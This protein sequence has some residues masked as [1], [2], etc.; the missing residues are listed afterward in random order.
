MRFKVG[1][2]G[3]SGGRG[4]TSSNRHCQ[5]Q[6]SMLGHVTRT[7]RS[8]HMHL[9]NSRHRSKETLWGSLGLLGGRRQMPSSPLVPPEA[10]RL[11]MAAAVA[12]WL[13][14]HPQCQA[15]QDW[16]APKNYQAELSDNFVQ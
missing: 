11:L 3:G 4:K 8:S 13:P 6:T 1:Q 14:W 15:A 16:A 9:L 2:E 12:I 10:A 5:I 7:Q